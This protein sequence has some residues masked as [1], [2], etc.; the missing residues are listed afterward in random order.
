MTHVA[1]TRTRPTPSAAPCWSTREQA[2]A[3]LGLSPATLKKW[4]VEER[5]PV[6]YKIGQ[7]VRYAQGDL[8]A[9]LETCR[10]EVQP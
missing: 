5:G 9:F 3:F 1:Q 2:A 6:Y 10:Q 4:A 7:R 8:D